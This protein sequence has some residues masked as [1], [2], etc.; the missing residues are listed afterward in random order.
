MLG[1]E[2]GFHFGPVITSVTSWLVVSRE[3]Q[4]RAAAAISEAAPV[5]ERRS[6]GDVLFSPA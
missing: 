5:R 6:G 4:L 2:T 3:G 1:A